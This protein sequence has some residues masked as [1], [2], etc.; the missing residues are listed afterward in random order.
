V[1]THAHAD[2]PPPSNSLTGHETYGGVREPPPCNRENWNIFSSDES[3]M[4]CDRYFVV[5][6]EGKSLWLLFL[7]SQTISNS[8]RRLDRPWSA[9]FTT[10]STITILLAYI[11]SLVMCLDRWRVSGIKRIAYYCTALLYY[12][13]QLHGQYIIPSLYLSPH[14]KVW[15]RNAIFRLK[16][17]SRGWSINKCFLISV[18]TLMPGRTE[19]VLI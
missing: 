12:Y 1:Y 2:L 10:L 16:I 8:P 11:L 17:A 15:N 14:D 5:K 4:R 7:T 19:N 9:P 18:K 6:A 3:H 13:W